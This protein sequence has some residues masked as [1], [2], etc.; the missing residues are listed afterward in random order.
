MDEP[1]RIANLVL[2]LTDDDRRILAQLQEATGI[3]SAAEVMRFA[4]RKMHRAEVTRAQRFAAFLKARDNQ[5]PA[6]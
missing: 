2:R 6:T 1:R 4:L 3:L 5:D